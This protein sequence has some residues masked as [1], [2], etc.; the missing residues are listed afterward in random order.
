M[1][2]NDYIEALN[3]LTPEQIIS[4][5]SNY[6]DAQIDAQVDRVMRFRLMNPKIKKPLINGV[7]V[8]LLMTH[9]G[10]LPNDRYLKLT[11]QSF[12]S[13]HKLESA[14]DILDFIIR[15]KEYLNKKKEEKQANR[16]SYYD[17]V[18]NPDVSEVMN[19]NPEAVNKTRELLRPKQQ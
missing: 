7:I 18:I 3:Q 5:L 9:K 12:I 6:N 17:N 1:N 11:L 8:L 10:K 2:R 13:E 14:E 19:P 16:K 15:R 4:S